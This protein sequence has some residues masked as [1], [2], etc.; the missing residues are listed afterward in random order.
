MHLQKIKNC[1]FITI[2]FF[3][4][5]LTGCEKHFDSIEEYEKFVKGEDSPLIE[6]ITKGEVDFTL[7][8]YPTD[9]AIMHNYKQY[10]IDLNEVLADSCLN[11]EEKQKLNKELIAKF[12]DSKKS[13]EDFLVFV[14]TIENSN[15]RGNIEFINFNK[16]YSDNKTWIEKLLFSMKQN[17]SMEFDNKEI[18]LSFYNM[19]RNFGVTKDLKFMLYFPRY[20]NKIDLLDHK[21]SIELKINEFCLYTGSVAFPC[22]FIKNIEYNFSFNKVL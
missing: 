8:Y 18:P 7:Q 19:E 21:D 5:L 9:L 13:T 10:G 11:K 17:I 15:P 2:F 12:Y 20:D 3:L 16:K 6:T 1:F 4:A 14:L 22:N